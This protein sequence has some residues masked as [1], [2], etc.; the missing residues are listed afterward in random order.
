M[1]IRMVRVFVA[2][3][4]SIMVLQH[5]EAHGLGKQQLERVESGDF[6]ISAWS[7]PISPST[8]DEIHITIAVE[9]EDGLVR[10]ADVT[11][12]AVLQGD[13]AD[14]VSARATHQAAANKLHYEASL[15]L[16]KAGTY[17]IYLEIEKD[18]RGEASFELE[19]AQG[20]GLNLPIGWLIAGGAGLLVLGF[21]IWNRYQLSRDK[22]DNT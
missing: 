9:N 10:N 1:R 3:V 2:L 13:T 14:E 22:R 6:R 18:G 4:V 20:E 21:V 17:I 15:E 11:V 5:V 19:V 16:D 12:R 7:D 8:D